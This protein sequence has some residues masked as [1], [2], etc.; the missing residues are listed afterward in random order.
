ML[1]GGFCML[2]RGFCMLPSRFCMFS[3]GFCMLPG[4][5]C[6]Q[7]L[8]PASLYRPISFYEKLING[9]ETPAEL[10]DKRPQ[11]DLELPNVSEFISTF[12]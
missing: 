2:P 4:G 6:L 10:A 3:G 9:P 12:H 1:P 5:F 8:I 11:S 7:F